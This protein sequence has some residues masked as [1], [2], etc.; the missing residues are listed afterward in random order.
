MT[1]ITLRYYDINGGNVALTGTVSSSG[2]ALTGSGTAFLTELVVDDLVTDSAGQIRQ[3][4]TIT[5]D[6]SATVTVAP[7][8]AWSGTSIKSLQKQAF[9]ALLVK[10]FDPVDD[11]EQHPGIVQSGVDGSLV[12]QNL[13]IRRHFVITLGVL[14]TYTD[15]LFVANF[16][17]ANLKYLSYIHDTTPVTI[18]GPTDS[19]G[20]TLIGSGTAYL[21]D[22]FVGCTV[23]NTSTGEYRTIVTIADNGTATINR[24]AASDWVSAILQRITQNEVN[25][26]VIDEEQ[27]LQTEWLQNLEIARYVVLKEREAQTQTTFPS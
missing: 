3:V 13:S 27:R 6:T 25:V 8:P 7:S 23:Y 24:A 9:N 11:I 1:S 12:Q 2:T 4:A 14:Q 5:N 21:T 26:Q 17:R 15:R 22:L 10:G 20:T 19:S 18:T 16:V